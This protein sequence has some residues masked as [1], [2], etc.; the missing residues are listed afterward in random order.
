M[1]GLHPWNGKGNATEGGNTLS[2][3]ER[4]QQRRVQFQT[5]ANVRE[6]LQ[7]AFHTAVSAYEQLSAS[8]ARTLESSSGA[9]LTVSSSSPFENRYTN[10]RHGDQAKNDSRHDSHRAA[11]AAAAASFYFDK[12]QS[13]FH[14]AKRYYSAV[15]FDKR[16]DDI[17]SS[18]AVLGKVSAGN[19]VTPYHD[20]AKAFESMWAAVDTAKQRVHWQTYICKDDF[21][22]QTTVHKLVQAHQ[23]GCDTE[24]LY[25]CGGNISGRS[26][27]TE[28]LTQCG[29][30]VIP[31]RPFFRS[32][33]RY[34][35]KG[36]DWKRS[37][38]LRNHRKILLVDSEQG[39]CGGLNIGNEY[40]GTAVGGTGKFRDTQCGVTGPAAAH[41][42]E[43][44][45]DT[46]QP[47]PW[48]Y[49][50]RRWRQIA[51]QQITRRVEEGRA[52]MARNE[53]YRAFQAER[54]RSGRRLQDIPSASVKV[55]R[56]RWQK[57][58]NQLRTLM[59]W[60][61]AGTTDADFDMEAT[62]IALQMLKEQERRT[63]TDGTANATKKPTLTITDIDTMRESLQSKQTGRVV[64]AAPQ[65]NNVTEPAANEL[66]PPGPK[67][68][69]MR[70]KLM[71]ARRAAL[72][73]ATDLPHKRA[74][75]DMLRR[76]PLLDEE[77]VPEAEMYLLRRRPTTQI[78]SCN[79]RYR[80]YSIQYA[81]W[82]VTR[83][84]HRRIWI[85]TPYYLPTRKLFAAL[86]Q[87]ARRGVDVRLLAG[88]NQT[89]DPWFMWHASNYI[90]ERLLTAGVKIYEFKGEQIMHAKT[91]VVDSMWSSIGSYNW[92]LMS[93]RNLEVCLCHLDLAV[94]REMEMQ[95]LKDLAESVEV[96]L[97]DHQQR[98]RWLR[99][100]SWLFY[101]CVFLLDRI[102]FRS[103]SNEDVVDRPGVPRK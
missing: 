33:L 55:M 9:P 65:D 97:E 4:L 7:Q 63:A 85:T 101:K 39:F 27:L 100:T 89:T 47:H 86:M 69:A 44:Y 34:F 74:F 71:A 38:G 95:F 15:P 92:D 35:V 96:R 94:A 103:F 61:K 75:T 72:Y 42:A 67:T 90:T 99:F 98:S 19:T 93:N 64:A 102:A 29:A 26:R 11:D 50:W 13:T 68:S 54:W 70:R 24:L 6:K 12:M 79:P 30:K 51:S 20:S 57:Q 25:D 88:S 81:L 22:G 40:C 59:Q 84:C 2:L 16:W 62:E 31:Y 56:L 48:K 32:V 23:R 60:N 91:V 73:R 21:V 14:D 46:K 37:P 66:K 80:D 10:T 17:L 49:G 52:R 41:L 87:A 28:E 77:P 58:K 43:V 36:L 3:L 8:A 82:Q 5:T 1:L 76:M 78:L 18:L 83:K 53:F 45:R